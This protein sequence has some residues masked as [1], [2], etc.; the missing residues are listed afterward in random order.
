MVARLITNTTK[1]VSGKV[2]K[3]GGGGYKPQ[4]RGGIILNFSRNKLA[5]LAG[6][7]TDHLFEKD[8]LGRPV[9][10]FDPEAYRD[11]P[12]ALKGSDKNET[13]RI[14]AERMR[15]MTISTIIDMMN[16]GERKDIIALLTLFELFGYGVQTYD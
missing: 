5:P 16:S 7:I 15:P 4:T 1:T 13:S 10:I 12:D 14:L 9:D 2:Y 11:L 6:L 3:L 8:F